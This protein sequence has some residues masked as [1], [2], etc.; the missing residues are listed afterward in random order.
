MSVT[1]QT[2]MAAISMGL[3]S[4]SLTLSLAVSKL[5]TRTD[6]RRRCVKGLTQWR[7]CER[8]VA[9]SSGPKKNERTRLVGVDRG[10]AAEQDQHDHEQGDDEEQAEDLQAADRVPGRDEHGADVGEERQ[11]EA[12]GR[13]QQDEEGGDAWQRPGGA[14]LEHVTPFPFWA[15][16][17]GAVAIGMISHQYRAS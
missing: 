9:G 4:L 17:Q 1:F 5:R 11:P 3:P 2:T 7:P 12:D 15:T 13:G 10:Q 6:T 8:I 14:L 16:P